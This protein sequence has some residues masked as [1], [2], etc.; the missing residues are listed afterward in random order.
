M[1]VRGSTIGEYESEIAD[2]LKEVSQ[3]EPQ[4]EAELSSEKRRYNALGTR[5]RTMKPQLEAR[6][7]TAFVLGEL[8]KIQQCIAGHPKT[9]P[10]ESA[11]RGCLS[12]VTKIPVTLDMGIGAATVVGGC[13][14][15][16]KVALAGA[17]ILGVKKAVEYC[18]QYQPKKAEKQTVP[19]TSAPPSRPL[20]H[21]TVPTV[22]Q[23]V[24][25]Q[26]PAGF[27]SIDSSA[28]VP[29]S[30]SIRHRGDF[31]RSST[32]R[33]LP[34]VLIGSDFIS[35][36][37]TEHLMRNKKDSALGIKYVVGDA[38]TN[39]EAAMHTFLT[40]L[41]SV[42]MLGDY[43]WKGGHSIT[44]C[45]P[46]KAR[47]VV[48][49]AAI[50]PDF[51]YGNVMLPVVSLG[52]QPT[53]GRR[54]QTNDIPKPHQKRSDEVRAQY[55]ESLK[56]HMVYHLTSAHY[57]P[58]RAQAK[59][60]SEA[61]GQKYL[62]SLI[63]SS[64]SVRPEQLQNRFMKVNGHVISMEMMFNTYVEQLRNEL[65]GLERMCPQGYVYTI[66]PPSIFAKSIG[67]A[68]TL[69]RFQALAFKMVSQTGR[70]KNLK[71]VGFN[72][73]ADPKALGL[74]QAAVRG[75]KVVPKSELFQGPG[76][77]YSGPKGY[78]LV[79]HNN[80]DGFGRNI[81]TEGAT[82]LDG[83]VGSYS[84]AV[85]ILHRRREDLLSHVLGQ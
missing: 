78:A 50:Q 21:Q 12:A 72:H 22:T 31:L 39:M 35:P 79:I 56:R 3:K 8:R 27:E 65:G 19:P 80:S 26:R 59:V 54:L 15:G 60:Y 1:S 41:C 9:F 10:S 30:T 6:G 24:V 17:A 62:E 4:S 76:A 75:A 55:D 68:G 11:S 33:T 67:G 49:S 84:D 47:R 38:V 58:S 14:F 43:A 46:G 53:Y 23:A 52:E 13:L 66:D 34:P 2:L 40:P 20:Q 44:L 63:T 81:E 5:F 82:S 48:M 32:H 77:S 61:D 18:S 42:H 64:G 25:Q 45:G 36:V 28:L 29:V 57:L 73:Y 7:R 74:F 69:N 71:C 70:L 83:V 37:M 51:E 85:C 16:W